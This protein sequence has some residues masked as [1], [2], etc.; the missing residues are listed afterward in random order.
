M[1]NGRL[2]GFF[3]LICAALLWSGN[4]VVIKGVGASVFAI[5]A[6]RSVFA[7]LTIGALKG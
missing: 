3:L 1:M 2:L 5:A 4:G 6:I 7:G